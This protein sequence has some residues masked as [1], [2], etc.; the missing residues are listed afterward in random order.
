MSFCFP[1]GPRR[2]CLPPL[3]TLVGTFC[4]RILNM[5]LHQVHEAG[6]L[7]ERAKA[8]A[9][10]AVLERRADELCAD[11]AAKIARRVLDLFMYR[12][13]YIYIF[14]DS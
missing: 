2:S 1:I 12:A 13:L 4:F 14:R 9:T 6:R 8:S 5:S 7:Y 10:R 3:A 11:L